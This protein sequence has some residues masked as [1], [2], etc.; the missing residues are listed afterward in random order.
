M[1]KYRYGFV[2]NSSSSSFIV[3]FPKKPTT[4]EEVSEMMFPRDPDGMVHSPWDHVETNLT[5]T[6]ASEIVFADIQ[7]QKLNKISKK[8]LLEELDGRYYVSDGKL[9]YENDPYYAL[10]KSLSKKY[11]DL[12]V[13]NDIDH[14]AFII[15]MRD[16]LQ[17]HIGSPAQ[18][19]SKDSKQWDTSKPYTTEEIEVYDDYVR[20]RLKFEETNKKYLALQKKHDAA[21]KKFW[22]TQNKLQKKLAQFDLAA[23]EH[24]NV[25]KYIARFTYSDN[26]GEESSLME[27]AGIFDN[28]RHI[29]ISHH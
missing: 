11:V 17:T 10:D 28:L 22:D 1:A 4:K 7:A 6:R 5:H 14:R 20:R 2:S 27:H 8:E 25:G 13:R 26:D 19:A 12:C 24:D 18:Y 15:V 16:L 21:A 23:F 3:A 9:Y 29:I